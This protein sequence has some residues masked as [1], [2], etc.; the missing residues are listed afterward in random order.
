MH[1]LPRAPQ[2]ESDEPNGAVLPDPPSSP[3][4]MGDCSWYGV[5]CRCFG[6]ETEA[7]DFVIVT[8]WCTLFFVPLIPLRRVRCRYVEDGIGHPRADLSFCYQ[9]VERLGL[10]LTLILETYFFGLL[11]I[12]IA[13]GPLAYMLWRFANRPATTMEAAFT[14]AF[15][16]WP[17]AFLIYLEHR[18][19]QKLESSWTI[20]ELQAAHQSRLAARDRNR[21]FWLS[22][23]ALPEW[24]FLFVAVI[25]GILGVAFALWNGWVLRALQLAG[26]VAAFVAVAIWGAIDWLIFRF[27]RRDDESFGRQP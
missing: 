27:V 18:R 7:P 2:P 11:G 16:F 14:M 19:K 12:V 4:F 21:T 10:S 6:C 26:P 22:S 17:V 5:G 9:I 13:F 20:D 8:Q 25:G 23:H 1:A 15:I 24:S 3:A